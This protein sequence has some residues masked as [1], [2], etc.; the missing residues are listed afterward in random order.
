MN[1]KQP[2][3]RSNVFCLTGILAA[4]LLITGLLNDG[5][6]HTGPLPSAPTNL[7]GVYIGYNESEHT[8]TKTLEMIKKKQDIKVLKESSHEEGLFEDSGKDA[9]PKKKRMGLALLF[10]GILAEEG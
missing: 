9:H 8:P 7:T 1:P 6:A 4:L 2:E 5:N 10:L 3:P